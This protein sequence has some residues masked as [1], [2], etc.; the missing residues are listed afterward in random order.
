[1]VNSALEVFKVNPPKNFN[2]DSERI[3][4]SSLLFLFATLCKYLFVIRVCLGY[5]QTVGKKPLGQHFVLT[6]L[7][8]CSYGK[9][10][11]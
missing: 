5:T 2:V 1:M 3:Q 9:K 11:F 10:S 6:P 8:F 4:Y 7:L